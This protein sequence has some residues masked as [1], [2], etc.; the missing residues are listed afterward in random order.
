MANFK[1]AKMQKVQAE[2]LSAVLQEFIRQNSLGTGLR[3]QVVSD[4][5]DRVSGAAMYTSD[6][7]LKNNIL[8]VTVSSSVVRS[9]LLCQLDYI[10]SAVN[11]ALRSDSLVGEEASGGK[12]EPVQKIVLR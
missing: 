8:Y 2:P 3:R 10:L 9:Q 7:Y 5:W 6:K 12:C 11:Q 1:P 4:A